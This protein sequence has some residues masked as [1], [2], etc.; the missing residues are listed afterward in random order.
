MREDPNFS[1]DD[2]VRGEQLGEL[3]DFSRIYGNLYISLMMG[4]YF[5]SGELPELAVK[6]STV[7]AEGVADLWM[8]ADSGRTKR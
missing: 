3:T 6:I 7:W 8:K 2:Y 4:F 5:R 1:F